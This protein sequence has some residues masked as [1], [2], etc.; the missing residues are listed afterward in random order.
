M[1]D[2]YVQRINSPITISIIDNDQHQLNVTNRG[3]LDAKL[4][5]LW[6]DAGSTGSS[7]R[8]HGYF[9]LGQQ[10]IPAG[11]SIKVTWNDAGTLN[12]YN[13]HYSP[14]IGDKLKLTMITTVGN[15]ASCN[16]P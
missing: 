15:L 11:S 6:V 4:T 3:G 12:N 7:D 14:Q 2:L 8:Y 9:N 16:Y 13:E 10:N 1:N 5:F